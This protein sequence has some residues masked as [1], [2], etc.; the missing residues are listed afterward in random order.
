MDAN[1]CVSVCVCV[2]VSVCLS[3]CSPIISKSY[4]PILMKFGRK[5]YNDKISVPFEDEINRLIRTE[6]IEKMVFRHHELRPFDNL[7]FGY[8]FPFFIIYEVKCNELHQIKKF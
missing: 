5:V 3:V 1:V 7:F 2:C 8:Y 6:V 4:Q